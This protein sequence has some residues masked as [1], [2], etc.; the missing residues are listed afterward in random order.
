MGRRFK[1]KDDIYIGSV[2]YDISE[3][4]FMGKE[5]C[6]E[7]FRKIF[8]KGDIY[9]VMNEHIIDEYGDEDE[10]IE[11]ELICV[12]GENKIELKDVLS[13]ETCEDD[14]YYSTV[15]MMYS[16]YYWEGFKKFVEIV[17]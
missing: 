10:D 9:E 11:I 15:G 8:N 17:D 14:L 2:D 12:E 3:E 7:C 4:W 13:E 1:I 16:S 6:D 5:E